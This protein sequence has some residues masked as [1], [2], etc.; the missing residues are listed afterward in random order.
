MDIDLATNIVKEKLLPVEQTDDAYGIK[1]TDVISLARD[2]DGSCTTRCVS[3]DWSAEIQQEH[4]V[5]AKEEP[6]YVCCAIFTSRI[7]Q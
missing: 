2:T 6:D 4:L 7:T 3:G 5:A 1:I